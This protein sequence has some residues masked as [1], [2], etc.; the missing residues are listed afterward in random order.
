MTELL[1]ETKT[2]LHIGLFMILQKRFLYTNKQDKQC[3]YNAIFRLIRAKIVSVE[4]Q[5]VLH[6]PSVRRPR[7]PARNAHAPYCH[8]LPEPLYDIF[9][10]YLINGTILEKQLLNTKCV[11]RFSLQ[12]LSETFFTLRRSE[13]V[14]IK[15]Y[16]LVYIYKVLWLLSDFNET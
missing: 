5:K 9:P 3:T 15:K 4:K 11:L 14:M 7:Y 8:L 13:Q 10:H 16:T 1:P 12:I 6:I 2:K